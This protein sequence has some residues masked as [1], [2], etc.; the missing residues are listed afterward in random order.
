MSVSITPGETQL[1][2]M[3]EGPSSFAR[4]LLRAMTAPLLAA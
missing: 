2:R 1:T 3:P 4:D